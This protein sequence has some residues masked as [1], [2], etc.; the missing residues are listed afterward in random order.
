MSGSI[1]LEQLRREAKALLKSCHAADRGALERM[2]AQ[3]PRLAVLND[4]DMAAQIKLADVHHAMAR[5]LGYSNWGDLKRHDQPV[6]RFLAAVRSGALE[7][8]QEEL[9]RSPDLARESIHVACSLGDAD[10]VRYHLDRTPTLISLEEQ[11]WQPLL[12]VCG[13]PFNRL[14]PRH[15]FGLHECAKVLLDRGADRDAFS[16]ADPSDPESKISARTR[17][18]MNNN[19]LVLLL[20]AQLGAPADPQMAKFMM[21]RARAT[22]NPSGYSILDYLND[23]AFR[24]EL[25][26]RMA[27]IRA[28]RSRKPLDLAQMSIKDVFMIEGDDG[29]EMRD[30]NLTMFQLAFER[31]ADPNRQSGPN[32]ETALHMCAK[33]TEGELGQP[34]AQLFLEHGADPTIA[35]SDGR[36]PYAIAVREGNAA[37]AALLLTHGARQAATPE[38]EFIGACRRVDPDTAWSVLRT[39]PN[40]LKSIASESARLLDHATVRNQLAAVKLMAELGFDLAVFGDRGASQLHLAAWYGHADL[41]RFLVEHHIPINVRDTVYGTSPLAW[42][43]HGSSSSKNWRDADDDYCAIVETL[44]KAG[45]SYEAARNRWGVGPEKIASER[46]AALLRFHKQ[47]L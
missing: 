31:G 38:D 43:A 29:G 2:R 35:A 7:S 19:R 41:V 28:R 11:G 25:H 17:A 1:N 16:L 47:D 9:R 24:E 6:A 23:P 42:A 4:Q 10:A 27:P 26:R 12:Y 37:V 44:I 5:E 18:T 33:M 32:K 34:L 39:H 46:V 15:G 22:D 20:L 14:S 36:T 21:N 40:V 3:L 45:A 30:S 8:A 13:S